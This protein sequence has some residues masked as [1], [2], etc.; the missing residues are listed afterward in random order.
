MIPGETGE[1]KKLSWI[2]EED[3]SHPS[4]L[5]EDGNQGRQKVSEGKR[6]QTEWSSETHLIQ[7]VTTLG[8]EMRF[9]N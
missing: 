9:W 4:S 7:F 3:T 6:Q 8:N 5:H 1:G 2:P